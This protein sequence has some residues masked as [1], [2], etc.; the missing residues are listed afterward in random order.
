M[1]AST[2]LFMLLPLI[3]LVDPLVVALLVVT[4]IF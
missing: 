2:N 3:A 4:Y 1:T